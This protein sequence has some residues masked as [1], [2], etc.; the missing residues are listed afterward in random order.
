MAL[1]NGV[2]SIQAAGYNGAHAVIHLE[3]FA[4]DSNPKDN[5]MSKLRWQMHIFPRYDVF[6]AYLGKK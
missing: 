6:I 3:N 1:K 2:K 4:W 5:L